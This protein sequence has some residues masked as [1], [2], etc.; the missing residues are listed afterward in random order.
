MAT[1]E[2]AANARQLIRMW[3]GTGW[4]PSRRPHPTKRHGR[5]RGRK[6]LAW[7]L[8]A[9]RLSEAVRTF[10]GTMKGWARV[11]SRIVKARLQR[12]G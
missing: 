1:K 11:P 3:R 5:A 4:S 2:Q 7:L 9:D 8:R 6:E 10:G 12:L